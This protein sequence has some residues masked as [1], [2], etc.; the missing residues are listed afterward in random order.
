[1]QVFADEALGVFE[2]GHGEFELRSEA[3]VEGDALRRAEGFDEAFEVCR[4][5]GGELGNALLRGEGEDLAD[6]GVVE[7]GCASAGGAA[8]ISIWRGRC[9]WLEGEC[10]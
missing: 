5:H 8:F 10:V 6:G 9:S 7:C 3:G 4:L 1:M 2:S